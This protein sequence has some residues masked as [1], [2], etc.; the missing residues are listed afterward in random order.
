MQSASSQTVIEN[1]KIVR[2]IENPTMEQSFSV[3]IRNKFDTF[4]EAATIHGLSNIRRARHW[5]TRLLWSAVVL[6]QAGFLTYIFVT[7]I[8]TYLNYHGEKGSTE[9]SWNEETVMDM[10]DI[11]ICASS[12][13]KRSAIKGQS[14]HS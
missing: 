3:L 10:P 6:T 13:F 7:Y 4:C 8:N 14:V 12:P 11:T 2:K 9:M 5:L 1:S